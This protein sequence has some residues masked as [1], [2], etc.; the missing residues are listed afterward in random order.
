MRYL[1]TG[2]FTFLIL[3]A[4]AWVTPAHADVYMFK[5][6]DG[7][8]HFTNIKPK[9]RTFKRLYRTGP[10]K[11]SGR[12]CKGCDVVPARDGSAARFS[13]YD[14]FIY[15][16]ARL[17]RIPVALIRAVIHT[18]S[19]FDPRVVSSAGARGLM[20]LLPATAR[21]MGVTDI[22]DPRQ[23]I[24]GGVRYLRV[25][26]NTF[27]GNLLLTVAGYHAGPN[28]VLKYRGIPPYETTQ[29]YVRLVIKRYYKYQRQEA[30]RRKAGNAAP[31][32]T[33]G[34]GSSGPAPGANRA[35]PE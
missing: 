1:T 22:F 8:T 33:T 14:K 4:L 32:D 28:N 13:R 16:A 2:V 21:H 20:Q 6:K 26:A 5:D 15:G 9:G 3:I 17:Y 18:E 7:V 23:N 19:D 12:R 31:P 30:A 11:A 27:H 25:L 29:R 35:V 10:G 24:Y 34:S